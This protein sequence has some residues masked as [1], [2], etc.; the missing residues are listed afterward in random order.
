MHFLCN[1]YQVPPLMTSLLLHSNLF[2][3]S[4]LISWTWIHHIALVPLQI[5]LYLD[6]HEPQMQIQ[7]HELHQNPIHL[8]SFTSKMEVQKTAEKFFS[9][10]NNSMNFIFS[11][12]KHNPSNKGPENTSK[13]FSKVNY[14]SRTIN[15][16]TE[17]NFPPFSQH[18]NR[19]RQNG[20]PE[21]S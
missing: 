3:Q 8:L 2:F 12:A 15:K 20:G 7:F 19:I 1:L 10:N 17:S 21:N 5:S 6:I 18:P 13:D 11:T 9:L 14:S 4:K 16:H